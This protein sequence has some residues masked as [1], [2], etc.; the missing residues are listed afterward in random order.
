MLITILRDIINFCDDIFKH[1][2]CRSQCCNSNEC[3]CTNVISDE[4]EIVNV[5]QITP[6]I[7]VMHNRKNTLKMENVQSEESSNF[8]DVYN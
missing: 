3:V 6:P 5:Q 2:Y 4:L 7:E 8:E 1:I